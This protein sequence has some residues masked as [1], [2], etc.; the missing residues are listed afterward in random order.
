MNKMNELRSTLSAVSRAVVF[1][2]SETWLNDSIPN[3]EVNISSYV[4]YRRDRDSRRGGLL[5]YVPA[6]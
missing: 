4:Q 5:V 3:G 2:V 1:G 6:C